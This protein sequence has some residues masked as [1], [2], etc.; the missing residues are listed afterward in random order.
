MENFECGYFRSC[1][2]NLRIRIICKSYGLIMRIILLYITIFGIQGRDLQY[3]IKLIYWNYL[4]KSIGVYI[5]REFYGIL[6]ISDMFYCNRLRLKHDYSLWR[7][8]LTR[9]THSKSIFIN[10]LTIA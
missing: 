5:R 1:L 4:I 6:I 9:L 2:K 10:Y 3:T 7:S 8:M